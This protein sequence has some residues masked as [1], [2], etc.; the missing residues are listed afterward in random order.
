[1][2]RTV[3]VIGAGIAGPAAVLSLAQAGLDVVWIAPPPEAG[4]DPVGETLAPAA[5]PIIERLGLAEAMASAGHRPSHTTLSAWG[6]DQLVD[7]N[8]I[9]HL[10]GPGLVLDR[11]RFEADLRHHAETAA[12]RMIA[13]RLSE[14]QAAQGVWHLTLEGGQTVTAEAVVDASGRSAAIARHHAERHRAD[15][16]MAAHA[17]L[18]HRDDTVEPTRAVLIEAVETGWWYA[19]LRPD[20]SLSVAYFTDPDLLGESPTRGLDAWTRLIGETRHIGRWIEDAGFAVE[21]AP[22]LSSAGT[23]WL[24]PPAGRVGDAPWMGVGDCAAAF[25]PLSS[26][27][28]TTALWAG[29]RSGGVLSAALQGDDTALEAYAR[30]VLDGVAGFLAQRRSMYALER[31]FADA[32]F[33]QRRHGAG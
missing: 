10:E 9:L 27:G 8:A 3:A 12:G 33:W 11:A 19:A 22:Q 25:D 23:T 6:S 17:F 7:R 24:V 31:R 4:H 14:A 26:H 16:L 5:N 13:A 15:Q 2:A 1:M 20:G 30:S 32:P 18:P 29:A 21:A 28:L